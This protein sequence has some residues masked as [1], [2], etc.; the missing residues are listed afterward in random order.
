MRVALIQKELHWENVE[1]N[2]FSFEQTIRHIPDDCDLVILPEMFSTGFTMNPGKFS[3]DELENVP[4]WMIN[5]ASQK[6]VCVCGSSIAKEEKGFYNRFY[7]AF[8][9]RAL[10]WYDKKHLFRMGNESE[11]YTPGNERK[12]FTLGKWRIMPQVCYDLR[13][14]VWNRNQDD[15][16]FSIYVANWPSPRR[17]AWLTLLKARAIENQCYV[18][19]VN[20]IGKDPNVPY[21]GGSVVFSPKGKEISQVVNSEMGIIMAELDMNSL[22]L[23]REK[24]PA[25]RDRD[26]FYLGG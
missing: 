4:A 1:K 23:F 11:V 7:F 14:P 8:P 24:F 3:T 16:D 21:D 10:R 5:I 6:G 22:D 18:A 12:I 19:G 25:W 13:F 17:D 2:L 15:Y 9:D 26:S 20:R